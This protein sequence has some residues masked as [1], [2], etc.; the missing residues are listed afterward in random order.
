MYL[1]GLLLV[2]GTRFLTGEP[3]GPS[4]TMAG[5]ATGP[6][7][8]AA[9]PGPA[10]MGHPDLPPMPPAPATTLPASGTPETVTI[11]LYIQNINDI[12]LKASAYMLD[13]YLWFR[14]R[15]SI[16]PTK[17]FEFQNLL[18][19]WSVTKEPIYPEPERLDD[20][21]LYQV[22]HVQGKFNRKFDLRSFPL[23]T[24]ELV[25]LVEDSKHALP[26][27]RYEP[28]RRSSGF[29]SRIVL[30]GWRI[31]GF[32]ARPQVGEYDT[33]F[34]RPETGPR[35]AYSRLEFA[36]R[37]NR[38][39]AP[40]LMRLLLP[41]VIVLFSCFAVFY[42]SPTY[43]DARVDVPTAVLFTMVA[44]HLTITADLPPVSYARLI[45]HIYNLSYLVIFLALGASI[46]AVRRRDDGDEAGALAIDR[47]ARLLLPLLA[48]GGICLLLA[49][50]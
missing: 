32:E 30:P 23:D 41:I 7:S 40:Y 17:T 49:L 1:A 35:E 38:P 42:I 13:F 36:L 2:L 47:R 29:S 33:D 44:L 37:I 10:A 50:G 14:W 22:F 16:D 9:L 31:T 45:D 25:V 8:T 12:D 39:L 15:G 27:V 3:V 4:P 21:S 28:D 20:G 19:S 5:P 11:G 43:A 46:V 26:S 48:F 6:A 34:G 24:Q 18:D